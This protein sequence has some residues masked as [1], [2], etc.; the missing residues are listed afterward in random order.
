MVADQL[1]EASLEVE[2]LH[3][4]GCL[5]PGLIQ[6]PLNDGLIFLKLW[7]MCRRKSQHLI[8]EEYMPFLMMALVEGLA[9]SLHLV[10]LVEVTLMATEFGVDRIFEV[11]VVGFSEVIVAS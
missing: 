2:I 10:L 5:E 7:L 8:A 6:E 9:V 3:P 1:L 4:L 11:S